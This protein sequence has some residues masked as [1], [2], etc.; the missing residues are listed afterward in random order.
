MSIISEFVCFEFLFLKISILLCKN[1]NNP[2]CF[3]VFQWSDEKENYVLEEKQDS[4]PISGPEIQG[5]PVV[6]FSW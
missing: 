4:R 3:L 2:P 1:L 5:P 6:K